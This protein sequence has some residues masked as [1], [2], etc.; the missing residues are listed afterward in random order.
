M[1]GKISRIDA[2]LPRRRPVDGSAPGVRGE[3]KVLRRKTVSRRNAV[4]YET[5]GKVYYA[6]RF[7]ARLKFGCQAAAA[8]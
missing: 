4:G 3:L 7:R 5:E 6:A 2:C 8:K 1:I